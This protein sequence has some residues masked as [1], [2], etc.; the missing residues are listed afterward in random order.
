MCAVHQ[1]ARQATF[2]SINVIK[3]RYL[4]AEPYI[5]NKKK[6]ALEY[7]KAHANKFPNRRW[8]ELEC[9]FEKSSQK[10]ET[11]SCLG[12]GKL[13]E[14]LMYEYC[15]ESNQRIERLEKYFIRYVS[16]YEIHFSCEINKDNILKKVLLQGDQKKSVQARRFLKK[17]EKRKEIINLSKVDLLKLIFSKKTIVNAI[18]KQMELEQLEP[19]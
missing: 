4:E 9:L 10:Q 18:E 7:F 6:I 13:Q 8:E 16:F 14:R 19:I 15:V 5:L 3:G 1:D 12:I 2:H 11:N 17:D